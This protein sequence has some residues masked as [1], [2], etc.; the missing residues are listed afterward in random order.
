MRDI[1]LIS[2]QIWAICPEV[3]I[4]Q[5]PAAH[6]GGDEVGIW[7]FAHPNS[8][9][10]V[11]LESQTGL[12]PFSIETLEGQAQPTAQ[13]VAEAVRILRR[14]LRLSTPSS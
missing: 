6:P 7:F 11:Q 2:L 14:L 3:S 4:E 12:C 13:S 5:L 10:E 1:D 8:P 9:F